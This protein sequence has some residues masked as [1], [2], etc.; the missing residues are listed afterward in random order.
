MPL[1]RK[2]FRIIMRDRSL[3]SHL[4]IRS[5]HKSAPTRGVTRQP[6]AVEVHSYG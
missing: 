2:I 3:S 4:A 6:Q 5:T 1:V